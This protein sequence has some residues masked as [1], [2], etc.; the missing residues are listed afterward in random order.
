MRNR[1]YAVL[2]VILAVF[3]VLGASIATVLFKITYGTINPDGLPIV[4]KAVLFALGAVCLLVGF[5]Y[6]RSATYKQILLREALEEV[7]KD[8]A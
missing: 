1:F 6:W 2:Y 7:P 3:A 5:R 8:D 4:G